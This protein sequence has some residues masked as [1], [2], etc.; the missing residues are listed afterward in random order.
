MLVS[1][2]REHLGNLDFNVCFSRAVSL[3]H[4]YLECIFF[5]WAL[6]QPC[7]VTSWDHVPSGT[8]DMSSRCTPKCVFEDV[9]T[10]PTNS[11]VVLLS[12]PRDLS[13]SHSDS[14]ASSPAS[15]FSAPLRSLL[16][17]PNGEEEYQE[18]DLNAHA[19]KCTFDRSDA[20]R[21]DSDDPQSTDHSPCNWRERLA[22][23]QMLERSKLF[24]V[25]AKEM[26]VLEQRLHG[27]LKV[28][29]Q[30]AS[31]QQTEH[32]RTHEFHGKWTSVHGTRKRR[33]KMS[34]E[35]VEM[36]KNISK[37]S[38]NSWEKGQHWRGRNRTVCEVG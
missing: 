36:T 28:I 24:S 7:A 20:D 35:D 14:G 1:T 8:A 12:Q 29:E 38:R 10:V 2:V 25:S 15:A 31:E 33:S 22:L 17:V 19:P 4:Y 18:D 27:Q 37:R 6:A 3:G 21:W 23:S 34:E 30:S 11:D 32:D 5:S 13:P 16:E 26:R 9:D